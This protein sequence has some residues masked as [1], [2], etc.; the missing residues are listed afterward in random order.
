MQVSPSSAFTIPAV[1][2]IVIDCS[3]IDTADKALSLVSHFKSLISGR[4][5]AAPKPTYIYTGGLWSWARSGSGL[6]SWTDERQPR[7]D[8]NTNVSWRKDV[9]DPVLLGQS[10]S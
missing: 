10:S 7:T 2:N 8:I 1:L 3:A 9:E 6:D 4:P 5:A